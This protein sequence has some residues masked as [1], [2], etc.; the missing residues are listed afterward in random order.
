LGT[1]PATA[2]FTYQN[3]TLIAMGPSRYYGQA[4]YIYSGD[5][6]DSDNI[7]F[8]DNFFFNVNWGIRDVGVTGLSLDNSSNVGYNTWGYNNSSSAGYVGAFDAFETGAG[9]YALGDYYI[10]STHTLADYTNIFAG[11]SDFTFLWPETGWILA[12]DLRPKGWEMTGTMEDPISGLRG[13][14]QWSGEYKVGTAIDTSH[15]CVIDPHEFKANTFSG[16]GSYNLLD[17][18][19]T[20]DDNSSTHLDLTYASSGSFLV[21]TDFCN[22]GNVT[23]TYLSFVS[24]TLKT[25]NYKCICNTLADVLNR[26][27]TEDSLIYSRLQLKIT[28]AEPDSTT[29]WDQFRKGLNEMTFPAP[30]TPGLYTVY[31]RAWVAHT[32]E[33]SDWSNLTTFTVL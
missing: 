2:D 31:G 3:N 6:T 1:D 30:V 19:E 17:A 14:I 33:V 13:A 12:P 10:G 11:Y 18:V 29:A 22:Y 25:G 26:R 16:S 21:S 15:R 4:A 28:G 5:F 24:L 27:G 9:T 32:D 8:K 23:N 20:S 7:I